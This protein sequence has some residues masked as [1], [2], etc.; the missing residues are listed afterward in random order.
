MTFDTK[1]T[2]P[3]WREEDGVLHV[4]P[5]HRQVADCSVDSEKANRRSLAAAIIRMQDPGKLQLQ[6]ACNILSNVEH[7]TR[8]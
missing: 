7:S 2:M 3:S 8:T 1:L 6:W 5:V 4:L